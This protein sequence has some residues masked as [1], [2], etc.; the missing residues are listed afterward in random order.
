MRAPPLLFFSKV[1]AFGLVAAGC[2]D[3][4]LEEGPRDLGLVRDAGSTSPLPL[5]P[6]DRFSYSAR[7]GHLGEGAMDEANAQYTLTY[8]IVAVEDGGGA[9]PSRLT[10]AATGTHVSGGAT[11]TDPIDFDLWVARLGPTR[12][13]DTVDPDPMV[14]VLDGWPEPPPAPV[15]G[16]PKPLP[17]PGPFFIDVRQMDAIAEELDR[18]YPERAPRIVSP[19]LSSDGA[20]QIELEGPQGPPPNERPAFYPDG[21]TR[22]VVFRYDRRGFLTGL[23]ETIAPPPGTPGPRGNATL[24]LDPE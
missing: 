2:E 6:G 19:D 12:S 16:M 7:L 10:V 8:T 24:S 14:T 11:W 23:I 17:L 4:V 18:L 3:A 13:F 22:A 5:V 15:Q 1:L 20:W 21:S 9:S